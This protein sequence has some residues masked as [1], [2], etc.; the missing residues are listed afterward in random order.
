M[1][2]AQ[3]LPTE[4]HLKINLHEERVNAL[5]TAPALCSSEQQTNQIQ[6]PLQIKLTSLDAGLVI[7]S[8]KGL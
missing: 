2:K 3:L 8:T 7:N 4:K 1:Q 6:V 5:K